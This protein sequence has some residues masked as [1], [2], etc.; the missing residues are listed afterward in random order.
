MRELFKA[1]ITRTF[2]GTVI[3]AIAKDAKPKAGQLVEMISENTC[4]IVSELTPMTIGRVSILQ[5]NKPIEAGLVYVDI[6]SLTYDK[7]A[8]EKVKIFL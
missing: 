8:R 7:K 1:T 2:G 4:Q 6:P 3:L 5:E